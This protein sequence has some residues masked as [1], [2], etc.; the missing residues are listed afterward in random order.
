[1]RRRSFLTL[2]G[3]VLGLPL[4]AH[5]QPARPLVGWLSSRSP[6]DTEHL[7]AAFRYGMR[8]QGFAEGWDVTV[9]Y[10]WA[11]GQYDRLPAL[12]REL[13]QQ[14]VS[15][16]AATGGEPSALAAKAATSAIPTV[17]IIGGDPVKLGLA[18]SYNRPGGNATGISL[19]N[20]ALEP[21]RLAMLR[22]MVPHAEKFGVLLNPGFPTAAAQLADVQ[23]AAKSIGLLIEP[24]NASTEGELEAAFQSVRARRVDAISVTAD[25]F[26]DTRR[27]RLVELASRHAVPTMYQ[28]SEY[29]M[30]GGLVSYGIDPVEVYRQVGLYVGQVLNGAKPGDLAVLQ[31]SKFQLVVNLKTAR[32]LGLSIPRSILAGADEIIE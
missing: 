23:A 18:A 22:E 10:R 6:Q 2:A 27:S 5:A 1:M 32:A 31:A 12:A 11:L 25:P 21:K 16:L 24:L 29:V 26:F 14:N 8:E 19:T 20:I 30:V 15:V 9:E 13:A 17:F 28:F 7:L 3:A 4:A